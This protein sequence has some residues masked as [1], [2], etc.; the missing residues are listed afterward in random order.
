MKRYRTFQCFW[1][2]I[3]TDVIYSEKM[4]RETDDPYAC[5]EA[6]LKSF[7]ETLR[8]YEQPRTL[9]SVRHLP[10]NGKA[11]HDWEKSNLV[12][13]MKGIHNYDTMKCRNCP[14]TGK[15]HGLAAFVTLDAKFKEARYCSLS[16][17]GRDV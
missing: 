1:F 8:P 2:M 3:G 11:K 4:T 14:A 15:R 9:H 12:T 16:Q 13:I 5:A 10:F 6:I 17:K 7:N